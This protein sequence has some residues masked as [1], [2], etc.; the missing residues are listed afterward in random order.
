MKHFIIGI[1]AMLTPLAIWSQEDSSVHRL[2]QVVVTAT[3]H[4]V[5]RDEAPTVVNVIGSETLESASANNLAEGLQLST[6]L[7]VENTCQNCGANEVR[8]NGLGGEYSQLLIDSRPLIGP[9]AGIYMLE[10][11]PA[12]MIDRVEV[13][14]GGGSALYGSNAIAGVIN[15]ITKEPRYNSATA[16]NTTRLLG[17]GSVDWGNQH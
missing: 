12:A 17:K 6:G 1:V 2:K 11:L 15:I 10:L 14:R 5:E 7:R 9:L 3:Q 8:I 16:S 4:A 13:M